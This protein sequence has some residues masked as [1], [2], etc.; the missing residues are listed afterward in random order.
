MLQSTLSRKVKKKTIYK[1]LIYRKNA[2]FAAL[3][4]YFDT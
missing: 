4:P 3:L 2:V 1:N